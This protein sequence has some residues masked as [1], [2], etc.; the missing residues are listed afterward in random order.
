M[1]RRDGRPPEL[2]QLLA[3]SGDETSDE[4]WARFLGS[5]NRLLLKVAHETSRQYDGA[6]DHYTFILERLRADDFHRLRRYEPDG[7]TKFTTWLVVVARRLCLDHHRQ[8]YGRPRR[9]DDQAVAEQDMRR[10]LVDFVMEE[11]DL[12]RV[13]NHGGN[14]ADDLIRRRELHETLQR[15]LETLPDEERLTLR[16]KFEDEA[17]IS[18]IAKVLDVP[19]VFHVYR[20]INK[21]LG[22]LREELQNN[23]LDGSDVHSVLGQ[24]LRRLGRPRAAEKHEA[25]ARQPGR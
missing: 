21:I 24:A 9:S 10:R 23:G 3:A 4:A 8:V 25:L 20:R 6:M 12:E 1:A 11:V 16:L 22:E 5:H 17:A 19:T 13:I 2:E 14:G 15:A 7:R 18:D